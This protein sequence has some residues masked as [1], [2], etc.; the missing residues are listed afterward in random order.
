EIHDERPDEIELLLDG[1]RPEMTCE[2]RCSIEVVSKRLYEVCQIRPRPDLTPNR[3]SNIR[4]PRIMRQ[5]QKEP[6]HQKAVV[7]R[8]N[9]QEAPHVER[10]EELSPALGVVQDAGDEEPR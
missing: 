1:E 10:A 5:D 6:N 9:T 3:A 4:R 2:G 7:E 8:K